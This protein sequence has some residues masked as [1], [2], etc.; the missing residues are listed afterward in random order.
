MIMTN[1]FTAL[2]TMTQSQRLYFCT[3]PF[4]K[5]QRKDFY[6]LSVSKSSARPPL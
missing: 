5:F 2:L 4:Q 1:D 6:Q 3:E